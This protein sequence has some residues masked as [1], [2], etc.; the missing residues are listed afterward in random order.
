MPLGMRLSDR[1]A[2]LSFL[3]FGVG[4][5]GAL[6]KEV[7]AARPQE[8]L[9]IYGHVPAFTLVDQQKQ[10]VS[11][12]ALRGNVWIA[13]FVFTRCAGQCPLMSDEMARLADVFQQASSVRFVSFTVD[14]EHD[15]PQVL[16][17]YARRYQAASRHWLF[18]TGAHTALTQLVREGFRLAIAEDGGTVAEPITHSVRFVLVDRGGNIRGYYDATDAMQLR[19]LQR[20]IKR[21]LKEASS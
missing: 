20:D 2:L 4:I 16:A 15:T 14:P 9:P 19:Q 5:T 11:A 3:V 7:A 18:L 21:L 1:L 10:P 13:D 8:G 17:R 6:F 12:E